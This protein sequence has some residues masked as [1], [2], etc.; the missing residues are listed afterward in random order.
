M[1]GLSGNS[2]GEMTAQCVY[3]YTKLF[4]LSEELC[5]FIS[6]FYYLYIYKVLY[7]WQ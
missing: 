4:S 1:G 7:V 6:E 2:F 5:T 3:F